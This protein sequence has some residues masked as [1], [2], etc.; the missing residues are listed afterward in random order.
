MTR[1]IEIRILGSPE[2]LREVDISTGDDESS[3][4]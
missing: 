3:T 4:R 2:L 1:A